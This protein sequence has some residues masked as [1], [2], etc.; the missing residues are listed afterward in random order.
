MTA[1]VTVPSP[2]RNPKAFHCTYLGL[3]GILVKP[4]TQ[5]LFL[6]PD[7]GAVITLSPAEVYRDVVINGEVAAAMAQYLSDMAAGGY[8]AQACSRLRRW[9]KMILT[10]SLEDSVHYL[11]GGW[12]AYRIEEDVLD[13]LS[14][15]GVTEPVAVVLVD[16]TTAFYVSSPGVVL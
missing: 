3:A 16:G 11:E 9:R 1:T 14:H 4:A 2:P 8:A 13:D 5:V 12:D 7:S 15:Q 6:E 10:L